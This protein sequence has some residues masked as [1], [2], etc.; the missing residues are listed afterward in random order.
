MTSIENDRA[1][2]GVDIPALAMRY[3]HESLATNGKPEFTSDELDPLR[4]YVYT[5]FEDVT[6]GDLILHVYDSIQAEYTRGHRCSVCDR[7]EKQ[8]AA[9]G[10]DCHNE[11]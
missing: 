10:Y 11:C 6:D 2:P 9:I 1:E 3:I 5:R 4:E 7:T 8:N